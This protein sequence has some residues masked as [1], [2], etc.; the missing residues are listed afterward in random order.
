M[1]SRETEGAVHDSIA[2]RQ[3]IFGLPALNVRKARLT[4][5]ISRP[6]HSGRHV[7]RFE[8]L[9]NRHSIDT[10]DQQEGIPHPGGVD[11]FHKAR[12]DYLLLVS[13][14][15]IV[16]KSCDMLP[17]SIEFFHLVHLDQPVGGH[18]FGWL[19]VVSHVIEH[20]YEVVGGPI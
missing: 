7:P 16:Q 12:A 13:E 19:E 18:Y 3:P 9:L 2:L 14:H 11:A 20:E 4:E 15:G 10:V 17:A 6:D 5:N 1:V 8:V